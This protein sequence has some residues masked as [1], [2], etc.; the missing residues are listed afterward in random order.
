VRAECALLVS[1]GLA[2]CA[3]GPAAGRNEAGALQVT[4]SL[5]PH[6]DLV[7]RLAGGSADVSFLVPP[8]SDPH[9]YEPLPQDMQRVSAADLYLTAGLPFED[10]WLPRIMGSSAGLRVASLI[11]GIDLRF[12]GGAGAGADP[13]TWLS[14]ALMAAE[15]RNAADALEAI[16]PSDSAAIESRLDSLL[17]EIADLQADLHDELDSLR[18]STF[19]AI[20]PSYGYFADEF[21]LIQVAM[22][23][24][25]SEP[26]PTELAAFT[27]AARSAGAEFILAS[28]QFSTRSAEAISSELGIP[29]IIH[30]PLQADWMQGLRMLGSALSGEAP[31]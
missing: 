19:L 29:L 7:A 14:P 10:A 13:H 4:T 2:L 6:A 27:D 16:E 22:E 21:G 28:P 12:E 17:A 24:G 1:V 26:T 5:P 20:H 23:Q 30:D 31:R 8:G 11:K 25:G 15:A 3:C 18:G 9:T